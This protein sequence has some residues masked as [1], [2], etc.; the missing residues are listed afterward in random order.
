MVFE[1]GGSVR[2]IIFTFL[3]IHCT[4]LAVQAQ[5]NNN[6][7]ERL[8]LQQCID[9]AM[10]HQPALNRSQI[11]V[12]ITKLTNAIN[13]SGWLPQVNASGNLTHYFQLPTAFEPNTANPG[14]QPIQVKSG[15]NNTFTPQVN[16]TQAI[17]NPGLL[18]AAKSAH[19][20]VEQ[21]KQATDSSKISLVS[22]VSKAFYNLLL[23]IEQIEVL[24]ADTAE[25]K[26]SVTDA[27]HQYVGGIV[28]ETDYEE[29]TITL[30]NTMTQLKQAIEN[31]VPQYAV[32]KQAIG[33]PTGKQFDINYDT[34]R[35]IRDISIDT[36]ALLQ[37]EKRIEYQQLLTAK[38]LQRQLVNYYRLSFLPSISGFYN[39]TR[40]F[41]NNYFP[42]LFS[43]SYP[44]SSIGLSFNLPIFT[45]LSRLENIRKAK[46][47]EQLLDWNEADLKSQIYTEYTTALANYKS[48]LYNFNVMRDN[49][50]MA[51]RVYYVVSLQYKQ[52]IVAYLNVI[53]AQSNLITSE[54]GY[55]NALFQT[56][57]DKIDLEK[58]MGVI[59]Y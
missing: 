21:A 23:T 45:G 36:M 12:S 6:P 43:A 24:K 17:F 42:D 35:M 15:I 3:L 9:Y 46:L 31:V 16:V 30:N 50:R 7:V 28:D 5:S 10:V 54:T 39:Y 44:Y 25:L 59:T 32:L 53:T 55:I 20:Y 4:C 38:K 57:S 47:Q 51:Q 52:G 27:Y 33:Y 40:E 58:A 2:R 22:S 18:Y 19:L 41:E 49:V 13:L 1:K 11:N 34:A 29:A 14:G 48:S 8:T 26:R 56:L 37:F